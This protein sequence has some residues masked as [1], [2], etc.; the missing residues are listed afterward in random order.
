LY[1]FYL[2]KITIKIALLNNSKYN[3]SLMLAKTH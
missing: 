3:Q 1:C 2:K